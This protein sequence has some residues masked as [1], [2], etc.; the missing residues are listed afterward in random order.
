M[1]ISSKILGPL[2]CLSKLIL[3]FFCNK[4]FFFCVCFNSSCKELYKLDEFLY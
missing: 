4:I 3:V 2:I 1:F